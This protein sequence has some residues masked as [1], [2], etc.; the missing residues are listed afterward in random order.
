MPRPFHVRVEVALATRASIGEAATAGTEL[1]L[2]P[3]LQVSWLH[4]DRVRRVGRVAK[5]GHVMVPF[6]NEHLLHYW[7]TQRL[8]TTAGTIHR[9]L[10]AHVS[11]LHEITVPSQRRVGPLLSARLVQRVGSSTLALLRF[12]EQDGARVRCAVEDAAAW[13]L[14][15][16]SL[17]R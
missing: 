15:P 5:V 9:H 16:R 14:R 1:R 3:R 2:G 8:G 12:H 6:L 7:W 11:L 10:A 13:R 4:S 17:L